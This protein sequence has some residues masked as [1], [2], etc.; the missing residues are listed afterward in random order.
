MDITGILV[1]PY[2]DTVKV[3]SVLKKMVN[4]TNKDVKMDFGEIIVIK[5]V[6]KIAQMVYAMK[7]EDA[8]LATLVSGAILVQRHVIQPVIQRKKI[9]SC[10]QELAHIAIQHTTNLPATLQSAL[11]A[12]KIAR[13]NVQQRDVMSVLKKIITVIGV[14]AFALIVSKQK[15]D[16]VRE[17]VNVLDSAFKN[18]LQSIVMRLALSF[19][20]WAKERI[21][22]KNRENARDVKKDTTQSSVKNVLTLVQPAQAQTNAPIAPKLISTAMYAI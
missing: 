16:F 22:L 4:V 15:Q 12:M 21:V 19:V 9:A 5:D 8:Y 20:F 1:K 18:I 17:M 11:N 7:K 3:V 2:V 6:Q 10:I 13:T 14:K